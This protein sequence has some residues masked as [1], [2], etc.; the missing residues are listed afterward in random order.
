MR[1]AALLVVVAACHAAS[2]GAPDAH[3]DALIVLPDAR[4]PGDPC[5]GPVALANLGA[6]LDR[7]YCA[8]LATCG[9]GDAGDTDCSDLPY[10]ISGDL[11]ARTLAAAVELSASASRV[12]Y[13]PDAAQACLAAIAATP[14]R[15]L[16]FGT[17]PIDG[18]AMLVGEGAGS[19]GYPFECEAGTSCAYTNGSY[20]IDSCGN[21]VCKQVGAPGAWCNAAPCASG[22]RCVY[23]SPNYVCATGVDGGACNYDYDCRTGYWCNYP[24][25]STSHVDGAGACTPG[26]GAG[27]TCTSD[28]QCGG[29]LSCV[30]LAFGPSGTCVDTSVVG[31]A[32]DNRC[33]GALLCSEPTPGQMGTCVAAPKPGEP[34]VQGGGCGVF[35]LCDTKGTTDPSDDVC[36]MRGELGATCTSGACNLGLVCT[37]DINGR[38]TGTCVV[39]LPDGTGCFNNDECASGACTSELCST[40]VPCS[41]FLGPSGLSSRGPPRD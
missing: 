4:V 18:C 5:V 34:C 23:E 27:Q 36:V 21:D 40:F 39:P 31:A 10:P 37:A 9:Y 28:S 35:M 24:A 3:P 33:L 6:C 15:Q 38:A 16:S 29:Q 17:V 2:P 26:S 7:A 25:T 8:R 19:C 20:Y 41:P 22:E 1:A 30:G 12:V 32:C 14:C 13:D 11:T